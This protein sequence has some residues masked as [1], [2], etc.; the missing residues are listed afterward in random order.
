L[1]LGFLEDDADV[2]EDAG[3]ICND[4]VSAAEDEVTSGGGDILCEGVEFEVVFV[5]EL[6]DFAADNLA[7]DG[8][9]AWGVD[10]D[11]EC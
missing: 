5:G 8:E 4:V 9:T 11:G 6:A 3:A 2:A 7:L 10:G 1:E